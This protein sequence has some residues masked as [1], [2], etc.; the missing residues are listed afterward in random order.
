MPCNSGIIE[1]CKK[2]IISTS[3]PF[4]HYYRVGVHLALRSRDLGFRDWDFR[5]KA[6]VRGLRR[7]WALCKGRTNISTYWWLVRV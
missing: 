2:P 7:S 5:F 4:S 3:I 6:Q 1:P